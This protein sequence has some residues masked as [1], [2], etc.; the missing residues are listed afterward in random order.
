MDAG[1][2]LFHIFYAKKRFFFDFWTPLIFG[3]QARFFFGDF[4]KIFADF[5]FNRFGPPP[6]PDPNLLISP[7]LKCDCSLTATVSVDQR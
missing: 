1:F 7:N 2:E 3:P 6:P 4:T 5:F